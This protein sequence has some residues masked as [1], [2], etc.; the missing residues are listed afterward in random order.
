MRLV[1]LALL[2]ARAIDLDNAKNAADVIAQDAQQCAAAQCGFLATAACATRCLI[3]LGGRA[4]TNASDPGWMH[5]W[6]DWL[7]SMKD[8]EPDTPFWPAE[9]RLP[10]PEF[11]QLAC[12]AVAQNQTEPNY[13]HWAAFCSNM[14]AEIGEEPD[15]N[16]V[17]DDAATS[18]VHSGLSLAAVVAALPPACRAELRPASSLRSVLDDCVPHGLPRIV[19]GSGTATRPS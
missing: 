8:D 19:E 17:M 12:D 14:T 15:L 1:P 2:C 6:K 4:A 3:L 18:L 5:D 13:R 9:S 16:E 11:W 7:G 10:H